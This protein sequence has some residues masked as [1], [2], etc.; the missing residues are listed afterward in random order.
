MIR[1]G[2]AKAMSPF[3]TSP[4]NMNGRKISEKRIFINPQAPRAAK[5][6]SFKKTPTI[7]MKNKMVNI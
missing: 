5:N 7:I 3:T 1:I 2:N 4:I 6:M